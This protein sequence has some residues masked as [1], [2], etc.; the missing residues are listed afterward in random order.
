MITSSATATDQTVR[1]TAQLQTFGLPY[2]VG[3]NVDGP[4]GPIDR[5]G[6]LSGDP[7]TTATLTSVQ[8]G[9]VYRWNVYWTVGA[10]LDRDRSDAGDPQRDWPCSGSGCARRSASAPATARAEVPLERRRC[11]AGRA[12]SRVTW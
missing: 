2:N 10:G 5:L 7:A 6:P 3:F 11:R 12:A 1:L 8:P 4:G 9:S